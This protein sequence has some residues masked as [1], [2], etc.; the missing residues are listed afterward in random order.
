MKKLLSVVFTLAALFISQT[1]Y[2]Q[3]A[4]TMRQR[5]FAAN[6]AICAVAS[7]K[8]LNAVLATADVGPRSFYLP[9][10]GFSKLTIQLDYVQSAATDEEMSCFGSLN[11]GASYGKIMSTGISSGTGT[12][13]PYH[14]TCAIGALASQC[15]T[16]T[17]SILIDYD[18][19][20]YDSVYCTWSATTGGAS[21]KATIYATAAVGE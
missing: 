21:D 4:P 12:I 3:S 8:I 9:V 1:V 18:I 7:C 5:K 17:Y 16:G 6:N 15:P 14:D 20:T 2:A 11:G 19:R 10:G 13:S